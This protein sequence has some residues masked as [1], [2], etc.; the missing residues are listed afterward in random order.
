MYQRVNQ[1][2]KG[3]QHIF[4]II[5]NKKG[6]LPMNT[7]KK[8]EIWKEYFDKFLN[9]E[10]PSGLLKKEIKKLAK[11]KYENSLLKTTDKPRKDKIYDSGKEKQFKE[12]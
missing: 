6:K 12:K 1:F 5:R 4:S 8:A 11:L 9:T 7:M 2:K 10:E 3:Y